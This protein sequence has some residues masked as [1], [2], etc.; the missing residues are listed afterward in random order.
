MG[1]GE[2]SIRKLVKKIVANLKATR[3]ESWDEITASSK[4]LLENAIAA[5][6]EE[7]ANRAWYLNEAV[8]L[9]ALYLDCFSQLGSGQYYEA[10]CN[11]EQIE[12]G[13]GWLLQNPFYDS[14]RFQI[15]EL[16]LLVE[17]WQTLFPYG[18][19]LSPEIVAT[20]K[21]C[22]IC[23]AI[24]N[25]WNHCGHQPG[26]V[27]AG[28]LCSRIV[29][30]AKLLSISLV[31]DPVQKYSVGF[32]SG[33]NGE[34]VDQHDYSVLKFLRER[35]SEPYSEWSYEKTFALHPHDAFSDFLPT[36]PCP[37]ESGRKYGECCLTK[38]GVIR[39]HIQFAFDEPVDP[40][41]PQYA[42]PEYKKLRGKLGR[43]L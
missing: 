15:R 16:L 1:N 31:R 17:R 38:A 14:E 37:C 18:V 13:V 33:P 40:S 29:K 42:L 36:D 12:I 21:E 39:P 41:L 9:R 34:R 28:R 8:K 4:A 30:E 10:W 27:Y 23:G 5:N 7:A 3:R 6:S 11:L 22:G 19:F 2:P 43:E 25:P 35:I 24:N 20:R 32:L 26:R